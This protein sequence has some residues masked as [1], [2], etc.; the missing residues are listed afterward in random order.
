MRKNTH[1]DYHETV[2]ICNT[3]KTEY[4]LGTSVDGVR[5][6]L[7]ANCHPFYTGKE[8]LV[9]TDNLVDKFNKKLSAVKPVGTLV[10]KKQ[11]RLEK[12]KSSTSQALTLKDMLAQIK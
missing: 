12:K 9:D 4:K 5:V 1:P 6:E 7:C 8:M 10:S 11:K 3:C 2:I